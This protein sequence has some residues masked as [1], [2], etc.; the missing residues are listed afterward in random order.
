VRETSRIP[1]GRAVARD[2]AGNPVYRRMATVTDRF[3]IDPAIIPQDWVYEWKRHSVYNQPDTGYQS[4]LSQ[5]GWEPVPAERHDGLFLPAG[6]TG[7]IIREGLILMER[8]AVL[9]EEE[10]A[11]AR[12]KARGAVDNVKALHG[13][14]IGD[15]EGRVV[16]DRRSSYIT[17]SREPISISDDE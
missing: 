4:S 5:N 14:K 8:P 11:E 16:R 7:H 15:S 2:R 9:N 12:R 10:R 1:E 13:Q 17:E 3:Y 6:S